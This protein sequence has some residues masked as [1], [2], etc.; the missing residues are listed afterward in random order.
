MTGQKKAPW[1]IM[2]IVIL[3][4]EH[5][6]IFDLKSLEMTEGDLPK[7]EQELVKDWMAQNQ[8]EL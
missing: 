1:K 4:G 6:G 5:I 3:Y 8:S 2:L 7:R